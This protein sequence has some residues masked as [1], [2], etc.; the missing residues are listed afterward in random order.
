VVGRKCRLE[1]DVYGDSEG[2]QKNKIIRV[3]PAEEE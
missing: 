3:L 2:D 1:L